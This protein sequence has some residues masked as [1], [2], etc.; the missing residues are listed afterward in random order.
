[1]TPDALLSWGW[2]V[3]FLI[4]LAIVPFGYWIRR[5]V[6][7]T[8]EFKASS[9]ERNPIRNTLATAKTRIAAAIGLYSL[10]ASTNYL[11]GVF[12]PLYAQKTLGMSPVDS[13]WGAIG[14]SVAQIVLP[15]VFVV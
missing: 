12:I 13:L 15:S 9:Q 7:E 5:R 10:A 6:D 11:L 2:R 14:Y 3:P 8:P 1:M 4:G